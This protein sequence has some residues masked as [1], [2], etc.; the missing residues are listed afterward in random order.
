MTETIDL[1][2]AIGAVLT[3]VAGLLSA[4]A[5][6]FRLCRHGPCTESGQATSG[7]TDDTP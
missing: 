2:T 6:I 5:G 4:L 3:G 1:L 7:Y